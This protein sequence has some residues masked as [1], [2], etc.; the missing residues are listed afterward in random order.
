MA[1]TKVAQCL[2]EGWNPDLRRV[3]GSQLALDATPTNQPASESRLHLGQRARFPRT[4]SLSKCR[5]SL[6]AFRSL[7]RSTSTDRHDAGNRHRS[8][9]FLPFRSE[10]EWEFRNPH[11][12]TRATRTPRPMRHQSLFCCMPEKPVFLR[13]VAN[14]GYPELF[15]HLKIFADAGRR[16]VPSSAPCR[17]TR[18]ITSG[19]KYSTNRRAGIF[20]SVRRSTGI[21]FLATDICSHTQ[22]GA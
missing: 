22:V 14:G 3:F 9:G 20:D 10:D 15:G 17:W 11:F 8:I 12:I 16:R 18:T 7:F 2:A 4:I 21:S 13:S 5:S 6:R 1:L 19:F